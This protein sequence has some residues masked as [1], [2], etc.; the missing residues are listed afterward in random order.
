M[1]ISIIKVGF[2]LGIYLL[3]FFLHN[4]H[5]SETT[6]AVHLNKQI[7]A[8]LSDI[9]TINKNMNIKKNQWRKKQ[10][11]TINA[12]DEASSDDE[13]SKLAKKYFYFRAQ[14]LKEQ[15]EATQKIHNLIVS[16]IGKME[17]L[18]EVMD[19][20]GYNFSESDKKAISQTMEGMANILKNMMA[21]DPNN[22]KLKASAQV[23]N[24]VDYQKRLL[25]SQGS[26]ATLKSKIDFMYTL[27][28]YINSTRELM[29][30]ERNYLLQDVYIVITNGVIQAMNKSGLTLDFEE[31]KNDFDDRLAND[32]R[33]LDRL[34]IDQGVPDT[35]KSIDLDH[36]GHY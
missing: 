27:A 18:Q 22:P 20:Q 26:K 13:K 9:R 36:I 28:A 1:R 4:G 25:F 35:T 7:K 24:S 14:E 6:L 2:I 10:E 19:K 29:A 34:G 33:V 30:T 16:T 21:V 15:A 5:C 11:E 23:L 32:D 31:L 12:I 3:I 17:R 8:N